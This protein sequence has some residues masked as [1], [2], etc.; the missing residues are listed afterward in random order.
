MIDPTMLLR[1]ARNMPPVN[2]TIVMLRLFARRQRT[3]MSAYFTNSLTPATGLGLLL[4]LPPR[5]ASPSVGQRVARSLPER[6]PAVLPRGN[7]HSQRFKAI[8]SRTEEGGSPSR[9]PFLVGGGNGRQDAQPRFTR[10][11]I[12]IL[13]NL[14]L[15]GGARR[16]WLGRFCSRCSR[17]SRRSL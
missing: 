14:C 16:F 5:Q 11:P 12:A 15:G 9:C 7:A 2:S 3:S 8:D 10:L 4:A 17:H 6:W 1:A 13:R